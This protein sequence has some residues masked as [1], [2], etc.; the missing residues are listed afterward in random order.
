MKGLVFLSFPLRH[1]STCLFQ[2]DFGTKSIV[3]KYCYCSYL[4]TA[5]N[6]RGWMS[7][8]LLFIMRF[9]HQSEAILFSIDHSLL[10]YDFL[11]FGVFLYSSPILALI[12]LSLSLDTS[13]NL[14]YMNLILSKYGDKWVSNW[15][16]LWKGCFP[17]SFLFRIE[18]WFILHVHFSYQENKI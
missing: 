3:F 17:I 12:Y 15:V 2:T 6:F 18:F 1:T 7:F 13:F 10:I 11:K 5:L 16:F 14:G 8:N 4:E 9:R